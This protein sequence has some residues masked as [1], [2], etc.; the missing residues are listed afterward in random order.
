MTQNGAG[1]ERKTLKEWR[2]D[3]GITQTDIAKMLG[4]SRTNIQ[5]LE[6]GVVSLDSRTARDY[7]D[8]LNLSEEMV[9]LG[10]PKWAA[11]NA[12]W[13]DDGYKADTPRRPLKWWRLR[14]GLSQAALAGLAG[15]HPV[16]IRALERGKQNLGAPGTRSKVASA[17][18][19]SPEKLVLPGDKDGPDEDVDV[20]AVLRAELRGKIRVLKKARDFMR[21]DAAITF[22]YQDARDAILPDIEREIRGT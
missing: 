15:L 7:M 13:I 21:N 17:L 9:E 18:R 22:R 3:V 2:L 1:P 5:Y 16:T 14:R 20:T 6:A 11:D 12:V 10:P 19:V 8:A 4:C